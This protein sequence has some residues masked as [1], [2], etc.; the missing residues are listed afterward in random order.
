VLRLRLSKDESNY[1]YFP[2]SGNT[3]WTDELI[4]IEIS[5]LQR[6]NNFLLLQDANSI[7]FPHSVISDEYLLMFCVN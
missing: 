4:I 3:R 6:L 5:I 1:C 2:A 7:L